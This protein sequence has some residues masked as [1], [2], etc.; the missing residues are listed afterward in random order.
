[1]SFNSNSTRSK[2]WR[3]SIFVNLEYTKFDVL[4]KSTGFV[5]FHQIFYYTS[6][7]V[8]TCMYSIKTYLV[9]LIITFKIETENRWI[10]KIKIAVESFQRS[11]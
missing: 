7:N 9:L 6:L 5:E 3:P 4:A 1:M 2:V 10:E 8:I 11:P